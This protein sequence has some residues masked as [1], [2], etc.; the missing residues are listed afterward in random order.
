MKKQTV[1]LGELICAVYDAASSEVPDRS[2]AECLAAIST[3]DLL[4]RNEML[5]EAD[6]S[7][8]GPSPLML[9]LS[10]P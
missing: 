6:D 7:S 5:R 8:T 4:L 1:S 9:C 10:A 2:A 3:L